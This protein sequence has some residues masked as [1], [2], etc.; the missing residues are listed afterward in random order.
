[1]AVTESDLD[2]KVR[3]VLITFEQ[4]IFI[5]LN[6]CAEKQLSTMQSQQ[7]NPPPGVAWYEY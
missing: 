3:K 1:M 4:G 5:A 2:P 7:E 6:D